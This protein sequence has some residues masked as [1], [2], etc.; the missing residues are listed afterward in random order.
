MSSVDLVP[1]SSSQHI[2]DVQM[3]VVDPNKKKEDFRNYSE[4][5][6]ATKVVSK[7][8]Y[9]N[10]QNQTYEYVI[11]Q[12]KKYH[13]FDKM[14]MGIWE[15][16]ELLN[17]IFDD[18]DPD[19]NLSQITHNLQT[20]EAIRKE[21]PNEDWFQLTGLIHDLGKILAHPE[22]GAEPQWGV[23]GDTFPV[24]CK[25]D[26]KCVFYE[27]FQNNPDFHNPK[28]NTECGVYSEGCGLDNVHMSYG[29]DEYLYQA[30]VHNKCTLPLPALY[31]IRYHSFYP[32]HRENKY[33]HLLNDQDRDMLKW[34]REFNRFDLYSKSAE[35]PDVD[36]L[37]PYY[38][39]LI[40]KYFPD[41]LNW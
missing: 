3:N 21:F 7:F 36:K 34:I 37:K 4:S 2:T 24:G 8:Y 30:C 12:E 14:K 28:Y 5:N 11:G 39:G 13:N 26:E 29:H 18:S 41:T 15:A 10:H 20:A 16:M 32:L 19:T 1:S 31:M 22:F 33:Q 25:F 9:D 40:K 27:Y 23:V 6:S 17:T 35:V 38:M